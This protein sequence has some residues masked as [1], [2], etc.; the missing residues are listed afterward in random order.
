MTGTMLVAGQPK[1]LKTM[2][3]TKTPT[4]RRS[5]SS[6]AKPSRML[7]M[8]GT[9]LAAVCLAWL[10]FWL[11]GL[12]DYYQQYS[13]TAVAVGCVLLSV[14]ISL[15]ALFVLLRLRPERRP[16]YAFWIALY[17][18]VPFALLDAA[19]CGAYLGH[20]VAYLWRYWYLSVFY[21]TPWLTLPLLASRDRRR[22]HG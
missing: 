6:H 4:R 5:R 14:L 15:A 7:T 11:L 8:N 2:V 17:Y 12:P 18:T 1:T 9:G 16:R 20:G 21:L 10:G 19:Y 3:I 13:H 22:S